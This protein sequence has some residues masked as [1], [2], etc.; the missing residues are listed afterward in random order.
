MYG[1]YL[2]EPCFR[3]VMAVDAEDSVMNDRNQ[4]SESEAIS[5]MNMNQ[6]ETPPTEDSSVLKYPAIAQ[7]CIRELKRA[8][9][10]LLLMP[11]NQTRLVAPAREETIRNYTAAKRKVN[12]C[13]SREG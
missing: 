11:G 6:A 8:A 5:K 3:T 4:L 13:I 1:D 12:S 7:T 10:D 2:G 9:L